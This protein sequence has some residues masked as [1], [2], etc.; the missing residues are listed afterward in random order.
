MAGVQVRHHE[1]RL[2]RNLEQ[3]TQQTLVSMSDWHGP[4][5]DIHAVY[6]SRTHLSGKVRAMV[7]FLAQAFVQPGWR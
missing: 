1:P 2:E 5:L 4:T 6:P 7:D 3:T